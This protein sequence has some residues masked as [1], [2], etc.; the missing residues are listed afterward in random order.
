M[1]S[2][3]FRKLSDRWSEENGH[4]HILSIAFPLILS[5]G[6]F[7]IQQFVDRMFLA[8]YSTDA[9]AASLPV[10]ILSFTITCIFI[11][12]AGYVSVFVAQYIGSGRPD[13]VGNMVWQ[14][15]YLSFIGGLVIASTSFLA[16]PVFDL[17]G[18]DPVIRELEIKYWQYLTIGGFFPIGI[19]ALSSFFSGRGKTYPIMWVSLIA[20]TFNIVFNYLLIFGH[21]GFPE[22]GIAGAGLATILSQGIN[23][24]VLSLIVFSGDNNTKFKIV[25]GYQFDKNLFVRLIKFGLPNGLQFLI[26]MAAFSVFV[27]VIGR[28][29][30]LELTAMNIVLN[31]N[32]LAFMPMIGLGITVSI[33]VGQLL[34]ANR[35]DAVDTVTTSALQI[36]LTYMMAMALLYLTAPG[37]FIYPFISNNIAYASAELEILTISA[38]RFMAIWTMFDAIAIIIS[39]A[40]KG[41]GDT[42]FIM[43][44]SIILSL[45]V[46]IVPLYLVV[47]VLGMGLNVALSTAV[48]YVILT[49][50]VFSIRYKKGTWRS[51]RVI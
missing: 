22:M 16:K 10:G 36:G 3:L 30:T 25:S 47:E 31:V 35:Q 15:I 42:H 1:I 34:G 6:S 46:L 21:F 14:G 12:T 38:M 27:L 5:M 2:N 48:A 23:F 50:I 20:T 49:G 40:L 11:G 19:A 39:S 45:V 13:K 41:A 28:I 17:V 43:L 7:S 33:M 4:R 18:H 29:G 24:L 44:A 9:L 37:I 26:D 51:M 8:W 32:M